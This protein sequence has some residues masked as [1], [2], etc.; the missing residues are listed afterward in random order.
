MS[1]DTGVSELIKRIYSAGDDRSAWDA[2]LVE[3]F[4]LVGACAGVASLVDFNQMRVQH[5]RL[6]GPQQ[7]GHASDAYAE[8]F[9][10]DPV[11]KWAANNP[12]A[13]YCDSR[14]TLAHDQYREHPFVEWASST[15][16]S[17]FWYSGC[18][19]PANGLTFCA[20][21]H[22][23]GEQ[24]DRAEDFERFQLIFDHMEC[25][26]RLGKRGF[27]AESARALIRLGDDGGVEQ[28]SKGAERLL[29]DRP[30]VVVT[31]GR[32]LAAAPEQQKLIDRALNRVLPKRNRVPRPTAVMLKRE[33]GRPWIVV[34]RPVAEDFGAFGK[35][36]RQVDVELLDR[37]PE[38]A[39]LDVVQSLFDLTGRELQV[40]R[41]LMQ[42]HSI[43]SLSAT[44][45]I[46]RNTTRAHLR[47][48]YTKTRTNSQ[49]ELMHLCG[50]LGNAAFQGER[51]TSALF[52]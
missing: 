14:A 9:P 25:A 52:N 11:F 36:H 30:A 45:E 35:V 23:T 51:E 44:I 15:L 32:V 19:A 50:S 29:S 43:D 5:Y 21:A 47:S 16:G 49:A 42:G 22:F 12:G 10:D 17:A 13:R 46:S 24:Q 31:K 4:Q 8:R 6:Y 37:I 7:N 34:F 41:L 20:A 38:I 48:I 3:T 28:V 33:H 40:L 2:V 18:A 26:M 1:L 27:S 39:G